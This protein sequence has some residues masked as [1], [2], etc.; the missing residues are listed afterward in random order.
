MRRSAVTRDAAR[1]CCR[2]TFCCSARARLS[3][4]RPLDSWRSTSCRCRV[5]LLRYN[6][7]LFCGGGCF[8]TA[9]GDAL[10]KQPWPTAFASS[11]LAIQS[12][13]SWRT[14]T[15]THICTAPSHR[16][17]GGCLCL[18]GCGRSCGTT[19][20]TRAQPSASAAET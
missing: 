11:R 1:I 7:C 18:C 2:G 19:A 9:S 16:P 20:A 10:S 4:R 5:T 13:P 17:L 6:S 12:L 15:F 14:R 3:T 8:W